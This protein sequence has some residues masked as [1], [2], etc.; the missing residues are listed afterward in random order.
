MALYVNGDDFGLGESC[1]LAVA[2]ALEKGYITGTTMTANGEYFENAVRLAKKRGFTDK[3]GVHF[4]LTEGRPLTKEMEKTELFVEDG[5]FHKRYLKNP[6]ELT[7]AEA[8]AVYKELSAQAERLK[9]SGLAVARADSHHYIHTFIHLAPIAARVCL[10]HDI[11]RVRIDRTF[12]TPERPRITDGRIENLWWRERGFLTTAHFGR[13][14][15]LEEGAVPDDVEI[16]THPDYDK[17]GILIDRTGV[18]D[19]CPTGRPL[20][21]ITRFLGEKEEKPL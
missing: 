9:K 8:N 15:D 2:E 1:T 19:G 10:E 18:E 21:E 5:F 3:I 4:N 12:D 13:M 14:S 11:I 7:D 16:M 6:R 20:R 17:N